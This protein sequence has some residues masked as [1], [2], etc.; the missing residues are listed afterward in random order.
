[1]AETDTFL[2]IP[3][4]SQFILPFLLIFVLL[5]AVLEKTKLLGDKKQVHAAI[6]FVIA[7]IFVAAVFPKPVVGNLVLFFSIALVVIFVTLLLWGFVFSGDK[8]FA[9]EKWMKTLLWVAVGIGVVIAVIWATGA[10]DNL[11]SFFSGKNG[12]GQTIITNVVFVAIIILALVLILRSGAKK[13]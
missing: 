3:I 9:P 10:W 6:A 2:N 8:G 7:L 13:E 11:V 12:L 4:V 1:M 5:Y